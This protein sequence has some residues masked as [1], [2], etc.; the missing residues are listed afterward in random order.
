MRRSLIGN[1]RGVDPLD[2]RAIHPHP[3]RKRGG[4]SRN[5]VEVTFH[6]IFMAPSAL[7]PEQY[8]TLKDLDL[9]AGPDLQ[10]LASQA[11]QGRFLVLTSTHTAESILVHQL[12]DD[13]RGWLS[14]QDLAQ[15]QLAPQPYRGQT[16]HRQDIEA[17]LSQVLNYGL[18]ALQRKNHYHWGGNI[19]P[20]YDCSGL[21]QAA[22]ASAGIWLPRDS[23]QQEIFTRRLTQEALLPGDLIFFGTQRV[24]HVA[25]YLGEDRYLHSS[26]QS[27]GRNGLGIDH[28]LHPNDAIGRAYQSRYWSC[29]RVEKSY[30]SRAAVGDTLSFT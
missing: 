20:H 29:G 26:G 3:Q 11:A 22:F 27:M 30:V 13:Y 16:L 28:L 10:T 15:L 1:L 24:D 4:D 14:L 9:F 8:Q 25:L 17:R 21:V 6:P 18:Q 23:Y 5:Y 19:G 12:E 7:T 2:C